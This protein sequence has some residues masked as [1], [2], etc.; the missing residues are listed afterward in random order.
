MTTAR[1]GQSAEEV[2]LVD[3]ANI[4]LGRMTAEEATV[5]MAVETEW[6]VLDGET[7]R[8]AL[9]ADRVRPSKGE[10]SRATKTWIR[11]RAAEEES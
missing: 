11:S 7:V 3:V 2:C 8:V 6:G 5:M 4:A 9:Q 10:A 1:E